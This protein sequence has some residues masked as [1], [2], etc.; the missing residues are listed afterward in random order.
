MFFK[1][2]CKA[3]TSCDFKKRESKFSYFRTHAQT[4]ESRYDIECAYFVDSIYE[5]KD[6]F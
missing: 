2:S 5:I 6:I 3:S 4:I 1:K